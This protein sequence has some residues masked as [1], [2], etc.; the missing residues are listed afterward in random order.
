MPKTTVTGIRFAVSRIVISEVLR[1]ISEKGYSRVI[2]RLESARG[3]L[4]GPF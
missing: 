4:E 1:K 3:K 2:Q